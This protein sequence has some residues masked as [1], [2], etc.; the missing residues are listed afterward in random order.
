[1]FEVNLLNNKKP[2][3]DFKK[4]PI[5]EIIKDKENLPEN[6][7]KGNFLLNSIV[8]LVVCF[9]IYVVYNN[10]KN[11][12]KYV[13]S[14]SPGNVL[15]LIYSK[16]NLVTDIKTEG[17]YFMIIQDVLNVNK[18]QLY[19]D[20]LL[21]INS[22][23]SVKNNSK[24]LYFIYKWYN[25]VSEDWS[26]EKLFSV[27]RNSDVLTNELELFENK[28]IMV[29]EFN[30]MINLFNVFKSLNL[31]HFFNYKIELLENKKSNVNYYK[32]LISPND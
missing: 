9:F 16:D 17:E 24:K 6:E 4:K 27:L 32:I 15:S 20:S 29:S 26:I 19:Y 23:V 14:I 31:L 13:E 22:F 28:I 7:N 25:D 1:M 5:T 3:I 11:D 2:Q 12:K 8:F 18:E 21:N 10:N 30:E